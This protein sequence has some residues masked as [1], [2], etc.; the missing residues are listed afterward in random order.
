MLSQSESASSA[1]VRF[2][3]LRIIQQTLRRILK[4]KL[5]GLNDIPPFRNT[6]RLIGILLH[7]HNRC[8]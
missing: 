4:Y 1:Q 2:F 3:Y 6:Q 8:T 5:S 7:E